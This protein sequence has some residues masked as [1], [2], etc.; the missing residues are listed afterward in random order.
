MGCVSNE[1]ER[2]WGLFQRNKEECVFI[3]FLFIIHGFCCWW[4]R[5]IAFFY[6]FLFMLHGFCDLSQMKRKGCVFICFLSF[7]Y[8][9]W[10]LFQM[11]ER[12]TFH[13]WVSSDNE[14]CLKGRK[15]YLCVF[16]NWFSLHITWVFFFFFFIQVKRHS[17]LHGL[18]FNPNE[19]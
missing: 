16:F 5:M 11:K 6:W 9:T 17:I 2:W 14:F 12:V 13:Y 10:I 3:G 7:F 15:K 4:E 18:V 19:K 8:N 1:K